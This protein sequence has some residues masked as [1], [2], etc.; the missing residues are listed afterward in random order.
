MTENRPKIVKKL[1]ENRPHHPSRHTDKCSG[2]CQEM[3]GLAAQL[4][5][6]N[7]D[8]S[9]EGEKE[10]EKE[11]EQEEEKEKEEEEEEKEQEE[12]KEKEK[13]KKK[14]TFLEMLMDIPRQP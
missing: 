11:K 9:Q 3:E 1:I 7:T 5:C 2:L 13:K 12:E 10:K 8:I 6:L 14:K 4:S